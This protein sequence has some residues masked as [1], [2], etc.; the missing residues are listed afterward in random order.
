[1]CAFRA[2]L[3][4]FCIYVSFPYKCYRL[5]EPVVGAFAC[6]FMSRCTYRAER[7]MV[8]LLL[9]INSWEYSLQVLFHSI[10]GCCAKATSCCFEVAITDKKPRFFMFFCI[11]MPSLYSCCAFQTRLLMFNTRDLYRVF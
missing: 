2:H 7:L 6:F 5:L 11:E 1:M 8:L 3:Y 9:P 4:V 10:P